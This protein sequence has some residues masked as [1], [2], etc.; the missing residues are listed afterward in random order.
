[1]KKL[2][3]VT[4]MI[5][6]VACICS[7]Y[8]SCNEN[9]DFD[10]NSSSTLKYTSYDGN[11]Y[12]VVNRHSVYGP[13]LYKYAERKDGARCISFGRYIMWGLDLPY[14]GDETYMHGMLEFHI[15]SK[16]VKAGF[17]FTESNFIVEGSIIAGYQEFFTKHSGSGRIT[18]MDNKT[19]VLEFKNFVMRHEDGSKNEIVL[20]GTVTVDVE[21]EGNFAADYIDFNGIT[22]IKN[23]HYLCVN[24]KDVYTYYRKYY[25]GN[26]DEYND[27]TYYGVIQFCGG[28]EDGIKY[29]GTL[30]FYLLTNDV[31]AG[32]KLSNETI[33]M[34]FY[35]NNY[36]IK[37]GTGKVLSITDSY[38]ELE[39]NNMIFEHIDGVS[40]D[41]VFNGR[42][43]IMINN[44]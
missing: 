16:D 21:G 6:C 25:D 11:T 14:T 13:S 33:F 30:Y 4:M 38:I 42:D 34:G 20:N 37:S 39:F 15:F 24:N 31:K 36:R 35:D 44:I 23:C 1:M 9:D 2:L 7:S 19:A 27:K 41:I 8:S 18:K 43:K 10:G 29:Y 5:A 22:M 32:M 28:Q 3:L 17:E 26:Y 12:D 40:A